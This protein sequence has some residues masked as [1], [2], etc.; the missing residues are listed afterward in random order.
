VIE[1]LARCSSAPVD[2]SFVNGFV[3]ACLLQNLDLALESI[4]GRR[5][6]QFMS[7]IEEECVDLI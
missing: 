5:I 1:D 2:A 6:R 7:S 3:N 4:M